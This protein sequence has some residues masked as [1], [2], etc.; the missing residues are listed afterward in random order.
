MDS[1]QYLE[2]RIDDQISWYETKSTW[3]QKTFRRLR[4]AEI[5]IAATIPLIMGFAG[6]PLKL[7]V[8]AGVLGVA[9]AVI[10]G[11]LGLYQFEQRWVEYRNTSEALKQERLFYLTA[12]PPYD[13]K[14]P[15][16]LF[17]TRAEKIMSRERGNWVRSQKSEPVTSG[18]DPE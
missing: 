11:I 9:V 2:Q 15:F 14:D 5:V 3:S 17:V 6:L 10:A 12:T 18:T 4:V 7:A 8:L 13:G 16:T 1:D